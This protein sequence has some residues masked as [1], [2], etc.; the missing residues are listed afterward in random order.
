[1]FEKSIEFNANLFEVLI[2][3]LIYLKFKAMTTLGFDEELSLKNAINYRYLD[4]CIHNLGP[5]FRHRFE[6]FGNP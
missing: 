3:K 2:N 5:E 4:E 1:M 6:G